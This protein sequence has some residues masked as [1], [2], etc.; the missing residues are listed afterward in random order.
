MAGM[1]DNLMSTKQPGEP[2]LSV[3]IG[4]VRLAR[5]VLLASGTCGYGTEYTDLLDFRRIGG[6][7]TKSITLHPRKGNAPPRTVE[8]SAGM[9]NAIGLA[10][11]GLDAFCR[12]K[13]P[14]IRGL[15]QQVRQPGE[16]DFAV[17]VN[18]A[19]HCIEDY[20]QVCR[21]LDEYPELAGVELNVS[22]PNVADGLTF[23][24]DPLLLGGLIEQVRRT[25]RRGL[26]VVKLSPNV[27]DICAIARAAVDAGADALSLVNTYVGMA[28]NIATG[29]PILSNVTGGLSGPAI[30][31]LAICAVYKVYR[32]VAAAAGIPLFGLG[33]IVA[34]Q[35]AAEF[36]LAGASAVVVGT[37]TFVDPTI[38]VDVVDGLRGWL[39][40]R[41][42]AGMSQA[43]GQ[44]GPSPGA[45]R[46]DQP[47]AQ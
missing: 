19:G 30:K 21:K 4:K 24:T 40:G 41:G 42:F 27:T 9:L 33:G 44:A 18:V 13:I 11:I 14:E 16:P 2:D 3:Q 34:W 31:P 45:A 23:G 20:V 26:L 7:F 25:V 22:C 36:V 43:V 47:V 15:I 39:K 37:G 46:T 6:L 29:K 8:T 32:Q 5:P 12:D 35:D 28:I 1:S 10:N 17:F 38:P